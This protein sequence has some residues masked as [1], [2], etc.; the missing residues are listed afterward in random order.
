MPTVA[1]TC[2]PVLAGP[3]RVFGVTGD[4][5]RKMIFPALSAM[6][7]RGVLDMPVFYLE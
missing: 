7:R 4:L 2:L 6:A 3:Q 5:A 1:G